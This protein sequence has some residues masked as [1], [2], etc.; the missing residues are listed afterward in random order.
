MGTEL[1]RAELTAPRADKTA[2]APA[3]RLAAVRRTLSEAGTQLRARVR[4]WHQPRQTSAALVIAPAIKADAIAALF[5]VKCFIA[6]MLAYYLALRIG[7]NRPFWA[8]V[9]SYIIAQP[10]A[11]AVLSKA[12]FRLLGTIVGAAAAVVLVPTFVN[13]PAALSLALALWIG[14]CLYL[15]QLDRTPR[16]YL[17]LLA[18]YTAGIIGFPSVQAPGAIFTVAILRVQEITIGILCASLVHG[19]VFPRTV[20]TLLLTRID[21]ILTDAR[22]WSAASLA[23]ARDARL[24]LERRRLA[25]DVFDLH[26]LTVQLPF[27]TARILPRVHTVRAL[28]DRLSLLLPLASTIEDRL[29]ELARCPGGVPEAVA[30][31]VTRIEGW[32]DAGVAVPTREATSALLIAEA[33]ALEPLAAPSTEPLVWRD[34]LLLN[35]LSR[36]EELVATLRDAHILRDQIRSPSIR[37]VSPRVDALLAATSRRA[38]HLDRGLA[39]RSAL[40]TVATLALGCLFWIG[41]AWKDGGGAVLIAGIVCALFS[42]LDNPRAAITR[43]QIG[44]TIGLVLSI[45]YAYTIFPRITD[46]VTLAAALSPALLLMG[47]ADGQTGDDGGGH[48]DPDRF[49]ADG[50]A[51]RE[52]HA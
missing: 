28:Q 51:Q 46:F 11:G 15:S 13:E 38:L 47:G 7:L 31:I 52:L 45:F 4:R 17:F 34:M 39:L 1:A 37:T 8:V 23:G 25:V 16:A 20:T 33:R 3:A 5:S 36:L 42:G 29:A 19:A 27:D 43:V 6:A 49:P 32:I 41:T 26:Q 48:G 50:R 22:R 44:S 10:L 2:M 18:G 35:L 9:T 14:F 12:A 24:D 30:A 21:T 40:G